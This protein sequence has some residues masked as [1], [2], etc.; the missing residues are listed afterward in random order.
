M[1]QTSATAAQLIDDFLAYRAGRVSSRTLG[2]DREVM[3][4]LHIYVDATAPVVLDEATGRPLARTDGGVGL[5]DLVDLELIVENWR[6]FV[7]DGVRPHDHAARVTLRQFTLWLRQVGELDACGYLEMTA[8]VRA[9]QPL[10]PPGRWP[11][12]R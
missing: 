2:R 7:R 1:T 8:V 12:R 4:R 3:K 5:S 11:E 10:A 6:E 9:P